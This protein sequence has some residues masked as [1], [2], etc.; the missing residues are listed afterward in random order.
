MQQTRISYFVKKTYLL[1]REL[2]RGMAIALCLLLCVGCRPGKGNGQG[3]KANVAEILSDSARIEL[4]Y[5][6]N[7]SVHYLP[8]GV[9]LVDIHVAGHQA[10]HTYHLA[11]VPRGVRPSDIPKNYVQRVEVPIQRCIPT[12][13]EQLAAFIQLHAL[14][15]VKAISS[16]RH[17]QDKEVKK[18]ISKGKIARIGYEGNFDTEVAMTVRPDVILASPF[19]RGGYEA[20]QQVGAPII[21][22]TAFKEPAALGQAEWVKLVGML[23]GK[24]QQA[25]AFFKH[26]EQQYETYKQL[27]TKTQNRPTIFSGEQKSGQWF[28]LGG[29][30]YLAQLLRDAGA[31][32][33]P[34]DDQHT[35]GYPSDFETMYAMAA[36]ADYWR[37]MNSFPGKFSYQALKAEDARND[38]FLAFQ[39]QHVIYC[40]IAT[41]GYHEIAPLRPDWLLADFIKALHPELLPKYKPHF[42]KTLTH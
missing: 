17:L 11:L 15:Q 24:E 32:Y 4:R 27:A 14:D 19:K 39:K 33:L 2:R 1:V 13:T 41:S 25:N 34:K 40:N 37:V 21:P 18:L 31:T 29:K 5:A 22:Y 23:T 3:P 28:V 26:V 8:D 12:G 20:L 42:Y 30:S 10:Q 7:F 16:V 35:G 36:K 9:R 6:K 38:K